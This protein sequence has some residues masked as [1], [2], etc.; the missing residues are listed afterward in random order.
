MWCQKQ[1]PCAVDSMNLSDRH[2][3]HPPRAPVPHHFSQLLQAAHSRSHQHLL[4][5]PFP[6]PSSPPPLSARQH[7]LFLQTV[8]LITCP[9]HIIFCLVTLVVLCNN[10]KLPLNP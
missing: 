5:A 1:S 9:K 8:T 7:H 4:H 10:D 6:R 2:S 3:Q